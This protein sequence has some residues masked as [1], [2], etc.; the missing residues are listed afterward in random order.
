MGIF[1]GGAY[2]EALAGMYNLFGA[3]PVIYVVLTNKGGASNSSLKVIKVSDGQNACE[4]LR[5]M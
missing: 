5:G 3:K 1:L 2:Q 4:V